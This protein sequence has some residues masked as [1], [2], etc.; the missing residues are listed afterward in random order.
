MP[1]HYVRVMATVAATSMDGRQR[2]SVIALLVTVFATATAAIAQAT[3]LGKQVYDMTGSTLALGLLGLAEFMP[4]A[5]LVFVTGPLADR[6]DRRRVTSIGALGEAAA[7][8]ALAWYAHTDPTSTLPIF[9]FVLLFGVARAFVGPASRA[10]PSDIVPAARLPKLVARYAVAWQVALIFGPVLGGFLYAVNISLPYLAVMVLLV[11]GALSVTLVQIIPQPSAE[12]VDA[13][14]V[15]SRAALTAQ[16]T[17][18]AAR[19]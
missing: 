11:A 19:E 2:R 15:P 17:I 5:L 14:A 7:S 16:A 18:G 12:P 3:V 8:G 1:P 13:V 6:V 9:G 10:L 4:S